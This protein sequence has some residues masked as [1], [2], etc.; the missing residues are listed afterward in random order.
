[1]GNPVRLINISSI[2][3]H[4]LHKNR[5][6][7]GGGVKGDLI[8]QQIVD[9]ICLVLIISAWKFNI[10]PLSSIELDNYNPDKVFLEKYNEL[11]LSFN[12]VKTRGLMSYNHL[13]YVRFK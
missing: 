9:F 6:H 13:A 10:F 4:K 11:S 1:M 5:L 7:F 2:C 3:N 12:S 8:M